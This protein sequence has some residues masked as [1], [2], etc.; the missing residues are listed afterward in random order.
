VLPSED[1]IC[2]FESSCLY[3]FSFNDYVV[4]AQILIKIVHLSSFKYMF[5]NFCVELI[6]R[7][8]GNG[9]QNMQVMILETNQI[10]ACL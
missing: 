6:P 8:I 4:F 1:Y 2:E 10:F 9:Y 7:A 3:I 5:Q